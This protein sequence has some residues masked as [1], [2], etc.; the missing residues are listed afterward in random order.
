MMTIAAARRP[1]ASLLSLL[2]LLPLPLPLPLLLDSAR[3]RMRAGEEERKKKAAAFVRLSFRSLVSLVSFAAR[4]FAPYFRPSPQGQ[5]HKK[6][7][8]CR[9][10]E[11]GKRSKGRRGGGGGGGGGGGWGLRGGRCM[12]IAIGRGDRSTRALF[13]KAQ[14]GDSSDVSSPVAIW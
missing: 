1:A 6:R 2:L 4:S 10:R 12:M 3:N 14:M 5:R 9:P 7:K 8:K 11:R 13:C